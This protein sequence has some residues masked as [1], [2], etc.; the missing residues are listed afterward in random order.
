MD[1]RPIYNVSIDPEFQ[2]G[3]N[4]LG[5][6]ETAF[7]SDPAIMVK[8]MAYKSQ[9]PKQIFADKKKYRVTAP[10]MIP[11]DIYR[12]DEDGE[13]DVRFT[14]DTIEDLHKKFMSNLDNKDKFNMEHEGND[15]VPAY[16]LECWLVDNPKQDKAF[17]TFGLEVPKGTLMFTVQFTDKDF[18]NCLL[19]TSPSPRD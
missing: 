16:M 6:D 11:M 13:Y 7:T 10:A 5:W 14:E 8:G 19:Y 9:A 15:R 17:S 2:E 1:K 4:E 3:D 12:S 18:Y